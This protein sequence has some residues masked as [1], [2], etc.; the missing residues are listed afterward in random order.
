MIKKTSFFL[1]VVLCFSSLAQAGA[2]IEHKGVLKSYDDTYIRLVTKKG[3]VR[4]PK[5]YLSFELKNY[6]HEK[7][8]KEI[9]I[10]FPVHDLK[11]IKY[12]RNYKK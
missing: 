1:I 8:S 12:A 6:L 2:R 4:I 7:I 3:E 10:S 9:S 11:N 5:R